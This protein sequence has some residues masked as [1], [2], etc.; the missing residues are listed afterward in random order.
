MTSTSEPRGVKSA[1]RTLKVLEALG[2]EA[3]PLAVVELHRITGYPR[4]S[5]HELLHTLAAGRWIDMSDDGTHVAIGTQALVVGTSYLDR[6]EAIP[7]ATAIL[8]SLRDETGYT[9]HYARLNDDSVL[10]LATRETTNSHRRASRIGRRLP[11]HSTALGKALLGQLTKAE[12][13][14][15][16]GNSELT[17]VTPFTITSAAELDRQLD[18]VRTNGYSTEFGESTV[19]VVCVG[20]AVRYR[21]PATD[22]LS[23]S[24]PESE[25]NEAEICRVAGI[26]TAKATELASILQ[27]Q[28][29]R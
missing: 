5:L 11:A 27:A 24:I 25:A 29:I 8:E 2:R 28:G 15:V 16:L 19:G 9:A 21:I 1:E 14:V 23:C 20:A 4:S 7:F 18:Q 13:A 17:A 12:R 3:R 26:I 6:D 10:Y 22:A